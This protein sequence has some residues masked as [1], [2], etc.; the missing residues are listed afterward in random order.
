MRRGWPAVALAALL[1]ACGEL[2][3]V[4]APEPDASALLHAGAKAKPG[5][6]NVVIIVNDASAP[7]REI[8]VYYAAQRGIPADQV[9]HL[10]VTD[11][12]EIGRKTYDARIEKPIRR[13]LKRG[14]LVERTL[15]LITTLGVPLKVR[16]NVGS[17]GTAAAVDSELTLLYGR[18]RGHSYPLKGAVPNPFFA[19]RDTPFHH[20][21][22]PIYLVTRLAAYSTAEVKAMIDRGLKARNRGKVILDLDSNDDRKGNN[23]L[24][25]TAILLP[26]KRVVLEET[27]K[28]LYG[29]QD[30]IGYASWG[31]NDKH[32][33]RRRLGFKW[34]PGAIA[35]EFVSSDGRTFHRPRKGWNLG[36]WKD[37][38]TW[39]G[40]S[41][42]S[43]SADFIAEG[44]TGASGH[45][46]EPYLGAVPRP[47]YLF[48]AY[49]EGRNLAESFYLSIPQLSWMNIVLGDPLCTLGK[50]GNDAAATS[51]A[52][53]S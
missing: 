8:A 43:L 24:R 50:A 23:W 42:Q 9:C 4:P 30:V 12:E 10:E 11:E 15:Y 16:D 35:T 22:F 39:S 17:R 46:Y 1:F 13:F 45:V 44:A 53:E 19:Q 37:R 25:A 3:E 2:P 34:L 29:E 31:S 6:A 49:L 20:P 14:K 38:S 7:S 33:K 18:I 32:R 51:P 27:S 26:E 41:P 36:T 47:E 5:P 21:R 48:P 40:G 28:V 52:P